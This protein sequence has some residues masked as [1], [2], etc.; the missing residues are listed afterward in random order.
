MK[1]ILIIIATLGSI[2]GALFWGG[3]ALANPLF[4]PATVQT[5]SATGTP[6]YMTAGTGTSTL[7]WDSYVAAG[8]YTGTLKGTLLIQLAASSTATVLRANVEYSQDGVD[9][10]QTNA[11]FANTYSTT[12]TPIIDIGQVNQYSFAFASSTAGLGS[13]GTTTA[14]STRALPISV[15]TRFARFVFTLATGSTP[16]AVWAQFV[17]IKER[18]ESK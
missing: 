11:L 4:F 7:T 2:V 1:K 8:N 16:G 17:P 14:T 9:W 10:Y 6:A 15:P 12:S 18:A 3:T 5:A 13:V